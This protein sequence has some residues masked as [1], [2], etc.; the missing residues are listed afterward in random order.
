MRGQRAG[1]VGIGRAREHQLDRHAAGAQQADRGDCI[2]HPLVAQHA[3]D[4]RDR[5]R[6]AFRRRQRGEMA[7]IDPRSPDQRDPPPVDP[8]SGEGRAV[9]RVLHDDPAAVPGGGQAQCCAERRPAQP[10]AETACRKPGAETHHRVDHGRRRARSPEG[11]RTR[12][13]AEQ[14]RLQRDVVQ[15]IGA[16]DP[17]KPGDRSNR[18]GRAGESVAAPPPRQRAKRKAFVGDRPAMRAHPCRDHDL[19]PVVARRPRDRQPVRA[20]I[21]ILGDEKQQLRPPRPV[22]RGGQL[23]IGADRIVESHAPFARKGHGSAPAGL[24]AGRDPL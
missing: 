5:D 8:E 9:F 2:E 21:P 18:P 14:H 19:E 11:K 4:E 22:A 23:G 6:A 20:E 17:V 10:R 12:E 1:V 16:F 3:R 13:A 7:E 24:A 15:N